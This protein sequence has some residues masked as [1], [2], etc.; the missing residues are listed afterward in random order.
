MLAEPGTA[1]QHGDTVHLLL[2]RAHLNDVERAI[3]AGPEGDS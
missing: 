3:A 2:V 1:L